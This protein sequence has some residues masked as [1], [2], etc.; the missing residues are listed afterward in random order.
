V[1]SRRR[2]RRRASAGGPR[3]AHWKADGT[4]KARYPDE[5]EANR[6]AFQARLDHGV[7]LNAYV[8]EFCGGWHLGNP[9]AD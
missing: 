8:C 2:V 4:P 9:R 6:A 5:S 1:A 7:E 3:L